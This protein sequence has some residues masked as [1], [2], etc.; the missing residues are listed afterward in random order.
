MLILPLLM[1]LNATQP[2][3]L[4]VDPPTLEN[5]GVRWYIEGDENRNAQVAVEYRARGES[6]WRP[7]QPLL[8]VSREAVNRDFQPYTT[9]N[10]FAGSVLFV[11]PDTEYQVRLRLRDPDGGEA[12][13]IVSA[14]TRPEPAKPNGKAVDVGT[15]AELQSAYKAGAILRLRAGIYTFTEP[16][17]LTHSKA[18]FIAAGDGPVIFEGAGHKVDLLNVES[19]DGL[20]FEGIT[21]RHARMVMAG[22][23]KNGPGATNL[24]VRRCKIEDA[25]YGVNTYSENS[26]NWYIADNEFTGTNPTWYPRPE[27]TYMSPSHTAVNVYGQGNVVAHNRIARFSD[28]IAMANFGP[29]VADL[30]RH[31]VSNDYYNNDISWAQDDCIE[32]DYG[33]HNIRVY[34]NRCR[35][36]H[37]GLS[38]QPFYGGPVYL[39]RNEVYGVTA[40]PFKW[41]NYCAGILAYHN[42][43][44]CARSGFMS[45]DRWQNGHLRNNLILGGAGEGER[46]A[47]ALQTGSITPYSTLD[48]NGYRRNSPG[49]L[50]RWFD[51]KERKEYETLEEF[52]KATGL[53]RHGRLLD[54]DVFQRAKP[55]QR[56]VAVE[57]DQYDLRLRPGS[58]A[59][60]AGVRL[61]NI[62]DGAGT[63]DLGAHEV[64]APLPV[65]GP[66]G[67]SR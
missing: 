37:T 15:V 63:P 48:Y 27:K 36:A 26:R 38:V 45:F 32:T 11:R 10:L 6:R 14:R 43:L 28:G 44:G 64:G 51:G 4:V 5:I 18:S 23:R 3:Q 7:A 13:R 60:D 2:G 1:A 39:I 22:G 57:P 30:E 19:T 34:R 40:L 47:Y 53:E 56:G 17:K 66:R 42:T 46:T 29:P 12:E 67:G 33:A 24:T 41:H 20:Y 52:T 59:V 9:G 35:N 55:P 54:Y 21:F 50:I 8:R 25:I 58:A 31:P 49:T 16:W 62:N 65:Y 61:D